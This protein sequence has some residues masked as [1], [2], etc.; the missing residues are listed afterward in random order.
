MADLSALPRLLANGDWSAAERVLR[1]A[2]AGR[3]ASAAVFYNLAKVLEAQEKHTQR[4]TWLARA[5]SC[6]PNYGLAWYEMARVLVDA[7]ALDGAEHALGRAAHLLPNDADVALMLA[8]IRL[9]AGNWL[10]ARQAL[11]VF[12]SAPE[13]PDRVD[14]L[15]YRIACELGEDATAQRQ[16]L[17]ARPHLRPS[18]LQALTRTGRGVLPLNITPHPEPSAD[19]SAR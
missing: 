11:G 5:L 3:G 9:R 7:Q 13:P 6:D 2:A 8:Q 1:R 12:D 18:V 16:S 4:Q 10:G 14:L 15:R 17:L 19:V